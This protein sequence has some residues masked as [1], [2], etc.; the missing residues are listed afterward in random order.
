MWTATNELYVGYQRKL[1]S[2]RT[3]RHM[4]NGDEFW[5]LEPTD[6]RRFYATDVVSSYLVTIG[7]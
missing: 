4:I 6:K 1:L 5:A 3:S 2:F 7:Q